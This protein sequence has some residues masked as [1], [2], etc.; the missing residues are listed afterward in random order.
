MGL[1]QHIFANREVPPTDS[2]EGQ[3][4]GRREGRMSVVR[5]PPDTTTSLQGP[6][7]QQGG[8]AEGPNPLGLIIPN[9]YAGP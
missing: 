8:P 2:L 7:P 3:F 1:K 9:H 4:I 6:C 5:D